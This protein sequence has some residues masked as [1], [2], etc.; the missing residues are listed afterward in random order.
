M[1]FF[2]VLFE[3]DNNKNNKIYV[4]IDTMCKRV[5]DLTN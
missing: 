1:C 4:Y 2:I 5:K 3:V